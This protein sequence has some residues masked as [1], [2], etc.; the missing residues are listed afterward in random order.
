MG[1]SDRCDAQSEWEDQ[2]M[3]RFLYGAQRC[4]PRRR[5]SYPQYGRNYDAFFWQQGIHTARSLG[6]LSPAQRNYSQIEKEALALVSTVERLKKFVWGRRFILQTDHRPLLAL[7][8]R[9]DTKGLNSRTE[10]RLRR[11]ALRLVGLTSKSNTFV[12]RISDTRTRCRASS[13]KLGMTQ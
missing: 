6:R 2:S 9:S 10:A 3:R 8:R 12:Q 5:T 13:R 11:W 1:K 7:F 4:T